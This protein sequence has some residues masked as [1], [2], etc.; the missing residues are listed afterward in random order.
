MNRYFR[1]KKN[2][3]S[4]VGTWVL[5]FLLCF[6]SLV[7]AQAIRTVEGSVSDEEDMPL[8]GVSIM[9]KGTS[10]GTITDVDG[11]Y[12]LVVSGDDAVLSYSYVGYTTQEI[13]IGNRSTVNV[14][15]EE[16]RQ[17]LDEVVVV[18]YGT[19]RKG[20]LAASVSTVKN[21][22]IIR[23]ASTTTAGAIV[24]KVAGITARQKSG[25]PGSSATL[26][27][28]NMGEPLYVIDGVMTDANAFNNL[29]MHDIDNI[30]I[31]KDGAAAIYGVK[32]S[33][34]VVLVTTKSGN[35]NQKMSVN[36]NAYT[37][38]QQW[39]KYP[40]LLNAYEWNYANDM[41]DV[42][43]GTLTDPNV[44]AQKREELEKWRVGYYNPETGEDYRGFSWYD[45]FV[46]NAAPQQYINANVSGG[47][48][49]ATYYFSIGHINQDAVFKDYNFNRSNLTA[50][51]NVQAT[52]RFEIGFKLLGKIETRRNPALEGNDD[53]QLMRKAIFNLLPIN[54]P[55]ANDNP[56]YLQAMSGHDGERNM[57]AL[58]IDNA[59]EHLEKVQTVQPILNLKYDI[60]VNGLS[61]NALFSYA[62]SN[63]YTS[64]FEK[65]WK[66]YE[67]DYAT[68][69]YNEVRD[70]TADGQTYLGKNMS[71][72]GEWNG[73]LLL[74]YDNTFAKKHHVTAV[75][76]F[77]FYKRNE[78]YLNVSQKPAN[79]NFIPNLSDS[80]YN[81]VSNNKFTYTTASFIMRAGYS[82]D[83]RYI[84]DFAGRYD[85]SWRF[86]PGNQWG[87]FP[88]VSAA[89][90]I[91]E[92]DFFKNWGGSAW[93]S[94][95]KLRASYG[96]TGDDALDEGIYRRFAYLAGYDYNKGGAVITNNPQSGSE[97]KM[98]IGS[99]SKGLPITSV[100]WI[101]ASMANV[102]VDLGFFNDRLTAEFDMFRRQRNG[103][104]AYPDDVV[105]PS[106]TGFSTM[107]QNLNS[108][109]TLGMD[110]FIRWNDRVGNFSYF[111]GVN[112]TLA[113]Q[114]NGLQYG[115]KF[116]NAWDQYRWTKK[117]RWG[118]VQDG[119]VWMLETIGRFET[120]EQIDNYPVNIDG[121][122]NTTLLPGDL[123]F[124]DV[125]G[126]GII[127]DYDYRPLGYANYDSP[128]GAGE[129]RQPLLSFGLNLGFE[130]K[131][132]DF[133]ADFAGGCMNTFVADWNVKT[134]PL[135]TQTG[136]YY[137][138]IDVWHREDIY[139]PT[140]AWIP[141]TNPAPR[142]WCS[143]NNRW[144]DF[145]T[146]DVN[147]LRLRNLVVGYTLP[148]KWT[149]KAFIEK[150][151]VYFE[152]SNLLCWDTLTDYG[153]DPET[154][155]M[156]GFDYPQHCTYLIGIN[157]SF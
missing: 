27:I 124:K 98:Q 95:L 81:S 75:G 102:G 150:F 128:L 63:N 108:D 155:S 13:N 89:W 68:D 52:K 115:E 3:W 30:S 47:T 152:G 121:E 133:A 50:S 45:N 101:T 135:R 147:Y 88:S 85:A 154:S 7:T 54:R 139:D 113:R 59:G 14:V 72:V 2:G 49:R 26:Q 93:F 69:T 20:N 62:F 141:G 103:L 25:V 53:Y 36:I 83:N 46:D 84:I 151:R 86:Q 10:N 73:Q 58:T 61:F 99:Q 143:N 29:D 8:I 156:D 23:S 67:Y 119:A 132:I 9:E 145:Y 70:R 114:K 157:I 22:D 92:E 17:L 32:A 138:A 106:E 74:N 44:I 91:S 38:W 11:S 107:P 96:S 15:L 16:D 90:R 126:D 12:K 6:P 33:N 112:A 109:M 4:G 24:G 79:T 41:A 117:D 40:R 130:W 116:F 42:N 43:A 118:N 123:I 76:G 127:N 82:Y 131:G 111:V 56:D 148:Q 77:E 134:G 28:R 55:Y 80:E 51:Y 37:G 136:Y 1:I 71:N 19:Q 129:S 149:R 65:G 120:Q 144:S 105:Y 18:G 78:D 122:N 66:E 100:S 153:F 48:D 35:H 110:G 21:D 146:K 39:T 57:A 87:F 142:S 5:A 34:G 60:P 64:D 94:N 104:P 140:S 125:N 31:L 137:S 97:D